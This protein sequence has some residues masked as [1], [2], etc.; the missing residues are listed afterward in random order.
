[1]TRQ[2][3]SCGKGRWG[4]NVLPAEWAE[5]L[6][7]VPAPARYA[8]ARIIWWEFFSMRLVPVRWPDIDDLIAHREEV[9]DEKL[10]EALILVGAA[11]AWAERRIIVR[12]RNRR[13]V[14]G[15]WT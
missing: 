5:R 14:D 15:R 10:I 11:R 9:E 1:M 6:L 2:I 13:K 7:S 12:P 4:A 8:V 3:A